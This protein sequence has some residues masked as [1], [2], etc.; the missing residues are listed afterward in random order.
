MTGGRKPL[1]I[2]KIFEEGCEKLQE[3]ISFFSLNSASQSDS[4]RIREMNIM[5]LE[6]AKFYRLLNLQ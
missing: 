5:P 6:F 1:H 4:F 2:G 3:R